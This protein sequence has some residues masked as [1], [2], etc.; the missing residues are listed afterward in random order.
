MAQS[1]H[2]LNWRI[3]TSYTI[4]QL[5]PAIRYWLLYSK[6]M[7]QQFKKLSQLCHEQFS[8]RLVHQGVE[9]ASPQ[10]CNQLQ[11]SSRYIALREVSLYIGTKKL[12]Y[13][14]SYLGETDHYGLERKFRG[15]GCK[16]LGEIL[17]NK[18][19][20]RSD[21]CI[22]KVY[23]SQKEFKLVDSEQMTAHRFIWARQSSFHTDKPLLVLTEYFSPELFSLLNQVARYD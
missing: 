10:I 3:P 18:A 6:S 16:P 5:P 14:K 17:F 11:T 19:I 21:F 23:S 13:A 1:N 8:I 4:E 7:T 12:M 15:L 20:Q 22:A 2:Q 9:L